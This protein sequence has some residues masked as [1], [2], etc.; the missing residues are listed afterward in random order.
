MLEFFA[1]IN[2]NAAAGGGA[3]TQRD[4]FGMRADVG[5]HVGVRADVGSADAAALRAGPAMGP[6]AAR[7][8]SEAQATQMPGPGTVMPVMPGSHA[9]MPGMRGFHAMPARCRLPS[10][11]ITT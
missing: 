6:E 1:D 4:L 9:Q 10:G 8:G 11:N 2:S 5:V 3:R 7:A